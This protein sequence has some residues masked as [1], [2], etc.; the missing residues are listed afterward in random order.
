ML[1]IVLH[2]IAAFEHSMNKGFAKI[3]VMVAM[4]G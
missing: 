1:S 4:V 2:S 3:Q